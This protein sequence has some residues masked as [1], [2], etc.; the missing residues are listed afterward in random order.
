MNKLILLI[1]DYILDII[2]TFEKASWSLRFVYLFFIIYFFPLLVL[3]YSMTFAAGLA[4][5]ILDKLKISDE[6]EDLV[7]TVILIL[8]MIPFFI[9]IL[10]PIVGFW[11]NE[12][13]HGDYDGEEATRYNRYF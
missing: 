3:L 9:F 10:Q 12:I 8:F 11:S 2:S 7:S 4:V 13:W 1:K 5:Y 6:K